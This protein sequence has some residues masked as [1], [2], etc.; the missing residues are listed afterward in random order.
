MTSLALFLVPLAT[1]IA[2]QDLFREAHRL[3]PALEQHFSNPG[4]KHVETADVDGNGTMDAFVV[5]VTD[6]GHRLLYGAGGGRFTDESH[7]LPPTEVGG[8]HV[9]LGDL[10]GDGDVDAA[11]SHYENP[12]EPGG[13]SRVYL[14][15]AGSFVHASDLPLPQSGSGAWF[16]AGD[17]DLDGDLELFVAQGSL[18]PNQVLRNDGLGGFTDWAGALPAKAG[19]SGSA[20]LAD[21][22]ADGDLDAFAASSTGSEVLENDGA[23][24]FS[25]FPGAPL[26]YG[27]TLVSLGDLDGDGILDALLTQGGVGGLPR[28]LLGVGDG[29]FVELPT[30]PV[31]LGKTALAD[32]DGDGLDDV[33]AVGS[34]V[35]VFQATGGGG[36]AAVTLQVVPEKDAVPSGFAFDDLDGDGDPDALLVLDDRTHRL[37]LNA[38]GELDAF[39]HVPAAELGSDT[40]RDLALG[41]VDGDGELDALVAGYTLG[42][43]STPQSCKLYRGDGTGAFDAAHGMLPG[44]LEDKVA[45]VALTDLDGDGDVDALLGRDGAS[46]GGAWRNLGTPSG[47]VLFEV[48][49]GALPVETQKS[50]RDLVVGDLDGDGAVDH[51]ALQAT[52]LPSAKDVQGYRNLGDGTHAAMPGL[53]FDGD[54]SQRG[55]LADVD[56]D[57]DLDLVVT[58]GDPWSAPRPVLLYRNGGAGVFADD[59]AASLPAAASR[60]LALGDVDGDG[61]VDLALTTFGG[62]PALLLNAGGGTFAFDPSFTPANGSLSVRLGDTDGDGDVDLVRSWR[63]AANSPETFELFRNG[64]GGAFGAPERGATVLRPGAPLLANVDHDSDL[65]LVLLQEQRR[66]AVFL[67]RDRGQVAWRTPARIGKPVE[68]EVTGP[69]S[70][71]W[72]LAFS[73]AQAELSLAPFGML[74]LDPAH[75]LVL[76]SGLLPAEGEVVVAPVVPSDP[77]LLGAQQHWQ[78]L[79]GSALVFTNRD[80]TVIT[81]H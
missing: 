4:Y 66:L 37:W 38:S 77:A 55:E 52:V 49:P 54:T 35:Q 71:P 34:K 36:L 32:L 69:A 25:Y 50:V 5:S 67:N 31:L 81:A 73:T 53:A 19:A 65:D 14:Q 64:G 44:G 27:H 33:L 17:L 24:T 39:A 76:A 30:V 23:G 21:L 48:L 7:R 61:D 8:H 43:D 18:L 74:L 6:L 78:A 51:V 12:Y 11:L 9:A 56:A 13:L 59:T 3:L 75:V 16:S 58:G 70:A 20:E 40:L 2:N 22:D 26:S 15:Q 79:V 57:G 29:T 28:P 68:M 47:G 45:A 62:T 80:A 46:S 60:D 72:F 41:D 42:G 10:D 63:P 1:P